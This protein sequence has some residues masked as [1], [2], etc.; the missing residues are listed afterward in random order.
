MHK[1]INANSNGMNGQQEAMYQL[2]ITGI[3]ICNL[4]TKMMKTTIGLSQV[5]NCQCYVNRI[6]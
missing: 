2:Y 3:K 4:C 5:K 1:V 6:N